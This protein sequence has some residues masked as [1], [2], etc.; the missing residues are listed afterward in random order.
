MTYAEAEF[1]RAER[2]LDDLVK[3]AE[4]SLVRTGIQIED[5]SARTYHYKNDHLLWSYWFSREWPVDVET[6]RVTVRLSYGEPAL[7]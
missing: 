1:S 5:Q 4:N 3:K 2:I 6:A 7:P